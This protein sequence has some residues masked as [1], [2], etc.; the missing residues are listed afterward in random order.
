MKFAS[1]A[2]YKL[3]EMIRGTSDLL[4]PLFFPVI[5]TLVFGFA[6]SGM[7]G[8]GG[9]PYFDYLAPG[10]VIFALLL[11][12]VG[13]SASLAREV[14]KGTLSR[15]KLSLMSSFDLL[16]GVLVAWSLIA[17]A[18][19]AILFGVAILIGFNWS[20]GWMTLLSAVLIAWIYPG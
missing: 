20:G 7:K 13:V 12:T 16:F 2:H 14:A 1:I 15:L 18:Q 3:K 9:E 19:V 8:E 10:M 17:I 5:F 6:F 11:L 4:V